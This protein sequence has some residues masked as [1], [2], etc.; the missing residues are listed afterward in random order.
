[1]VIVWSSIALDKQ[2]IA[3]FGFVAKLNIE[4]MLN[5]SKVLHIVTFLEYI[6][7]LC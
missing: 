5:S 2:V 6:I 4:N 3:I 7:Y 1:M